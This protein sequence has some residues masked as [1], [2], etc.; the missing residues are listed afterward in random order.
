MIRPFKPARSTAR[1]VS[2]SQLVPGNTGMN[3]RGTATARA[4]R[5]GGRLS[6]LMAG[7]GFCPGVVAG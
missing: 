6:A 5:T 4:G 7:I 2:T 3:T 1:A